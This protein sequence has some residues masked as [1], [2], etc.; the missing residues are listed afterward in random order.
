MN[1]EMTDRASSLTAKQDKRPERGRLFAM[2]TG[3]ASASIYW[4]TGT[5]D[6]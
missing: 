5:F 6:G 3:A 1:A 2:F 4:L